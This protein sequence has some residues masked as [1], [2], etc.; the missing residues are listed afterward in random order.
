MMPSMRR[1]RILLA[2]DEPLFRQATS[3]LLRR[4]G[5][6]CRTAGTAEDAMQQLTQTSFDLL[7]VDLNMPGNLDLE[8]LNAGRRDYP[9]VPMI[10]VTGAPSLRSAIDS[11]RLG[12]SDYLLK[13]I[14]IEDLV[15]RIHTVLAR[16]K[17][18][19]SSVPNERQENDLPLH[20][21]APAD[22]FILSDSS[23]LR[24]MLD[25]IERTASTD[26]SVLI[27][28][29]SGTGKEVVAQALHQASPRA[30]NPFVTID[31]TAIPETLFESVLYGHAKGAFTGAMTDQPGLLKGANGGTVFLDEIGELPLSS[32]SKLLRLIQHSTFTPVGHPSPISIDVRFIAATNRDLREEIRVGRFRQDLFY[33]LAVVP[34]V[35]PPLR[36]RGDD[37]M[38]LARHFLQLFQSTK[39][40][41][42]KVFSTDAVRC[43]CSYRWPGNIRELRN[44]IERAVT[45][46]NGNSIELEDLPPELVQSGWEKT[47]LPARDGIPSSRNSLL[48]QADHDYLKELLRKSGGNVTRAAATAGVTRQ[49]FYK[50]LQK[51]GI[52]PTEF[53]Q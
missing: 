40:T 5:F 42:P 37:V 18:L 20:R 21:R 6:D 29:E 1:D 44:V 52:T 41:P 51:H 9:T 2:D 17:S 22:L 24:D 7:I 34:I 16:V 3:E 19:S 33:R 14:R 50:L 4:A 10:V 48:V 30:A 49:G 23:P 25:V 31:C 38:V 13:P 35:V 8:L 15:R 32:Q 39:Q 27:T 36:A 12:I 47:T 26:V 46:S 11:V 53:R 43:L 45:L 28:G